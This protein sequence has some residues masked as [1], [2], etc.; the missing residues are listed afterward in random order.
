[1]CH[2]ATLGSFV[3][4]VQCLPSLVNDI[5]NLYWRVFCMFVLSG[6]TLLFVPG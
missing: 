6:L 4:Y 3:K 5:F 2:A 1:M